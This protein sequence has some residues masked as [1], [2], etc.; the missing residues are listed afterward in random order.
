M[1]ETNLK[2]GNWWDKIV[3]VIA[4]I[5]L[6]LVVFNISYIPLRDIYLRQFPAVVNLYDPIKSITPQ[7]DT[8]RYLA[9]VG[10]LKLEIDRVGIAADSTS[11]ILADLRQQSSE[12]IEENPFLIANKF[13]TFAK[14]Q[15]RIEYRT[16][17]RSA[18][19]AFNSFW[20][21]EYLTNQGIA[22]ELTFF[23]GKIEPLLAVNY[24]RS[25]DENGQFIDLFWRVDIYF[26]VFFALEFLGRTFLVAKR[27]SGINWLDAILRCWYD[28]LMLLPTWRWLRAIPVAVKLHKSGLVNMERIIAQITH[29]PAAYL[30]D[31][32]SMFLMV[33]LIDR[34]QEAV[35][36]G[37]A[38]KILL[39]DPPADYIEIGKSDK[40]NAIAD[41]I[42][43]L[44]IY[45]VL[46]QVQPNL[47]SLLRY[48]MK[49]ALTQSEFYQTI[50]QVPGLQ[51]IPA[52][53]TDQLADYLASATYEVIANSYSDLKGRELFDG[54]TDRFK[55]AL[56]QE[57]LTR[58]TQ[59]ELQLLLSDLLEELKI[60]YV[61]RSRDRDPEATLAQVE[62]LRQI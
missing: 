30:A 59:S 37:D 10:Q 4:V 57:L 13:A 15:R 41:R 60:N 18:K 20:T 61:Q 29:E 8:Q 9:T 44:S 24:D 22:K 7:A 23:E 16:E 38:A 6:A 47:E 42:L 51:G 46:P 50:K 62:Q 55:Q 2:R 39:D 11:E 49:E 48:S 19:A 33:K 45:K 52:E 25:I 56:R 14:L 36:T 27:E 17:S 21:K 28:G 31:R 40:F 12:I 26:V 3:A 58:E 35:K 53:A 34:T 1:S 32:V 5:N 43:E 54:L